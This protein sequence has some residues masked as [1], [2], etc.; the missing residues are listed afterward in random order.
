M[1]KNLIIVGTGLFPEVARYYFDELS[2]YSVIGFACHQKYKHCDT[3]YG[4][5]L[6]AIENLKE[7]HDPDQ[8]TLFVGIGYKNM[9]KIRQ[10]VYEELKSLGY[11]FAT[12]V[13]PNVK[14]WGS[15]V[16]GENVFIFEDNTIQPFTR[17][18]NNTM[19]WSGNHIGHHTTIGDHSFISSHVVISGSCKVGNN[20]FVGVNATFH[21]GLTVA[22]ETLVG[23]GAIISKNTKPK[24][25]FVSAAT[26]PFPKNSEEIGF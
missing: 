5:P 14:I 10:K 4:L 17:I 15:S 7:I 19:L 13:Y 8:I 16:L 12:F 3:I 25:V 26:K 20:V 2:D 24:E 11:S 6:Y 21:D 9:N 1:K 23:A 18:G 22:D